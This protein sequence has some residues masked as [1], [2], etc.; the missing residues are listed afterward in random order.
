MHRIMQAKKN[1][2]IQ[3]Q[4]SISPSVDEFAQ[5]RAPDNL[6]DDDFDPVEEAQVIISETL[7]PPLRAQTV[8]R[9]RNTNRGA[10]RGGGNASRHVP[11]EVPTTT[12][13]APQGPEVPRREA[14]R[15]DRSGTGGIKKTKLT[16]AELSARME[17]IK[18]KNVLL[19]A[20]HARAE[21]DEASFNEREAQ[22]QEKRR[23]ERQ[24][25]QQM[26]GE[27][28]KNR[29]RKMKAVGGREWD[30]EKSEMDAVEAAG[31][32]QFRRGAYGGVAFDRQSIPSGADISQETHEDRDPWAPTEE[33]RGGFRERGRGRGRGQ[34]RGRGSTQHSRNDQR[35]ARE[36]GLLVPE[37]FPALES[38]S[39][40]ANTTSGWGDSSTAKSGQGE[41]TNT[42]VGWGVS[43]LSIQ[44]G[45]GESTTEFGSGDGPPTQAK[46][47]DDIGWDAAV[48][49]ATQSS[50]P[51]TLESTTSLGKGSSWAEE[52][53]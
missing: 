4:Q 15:G 13:D 29:L 37:D 2:R 3:Y 16:E 30:A 52:M 46:L 50:A 41:S 28:E 22:A 42:K 9:Q 18:L 17:A 11:P 36:R 1:N 21:A 44:P 7:Q 8:Q 23:Q 14:V 40:A 19:E 25:R 27:R 5:T 43:T 10:K 38:G 33:V 12:E 39:K 26:M 51:S 53:D 32:S 20:A 34:G 31:R 47:A 45:Q 6:F 24:N 35:S 48:P 49:A